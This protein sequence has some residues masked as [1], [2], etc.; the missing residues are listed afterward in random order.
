[1]EW[2]LTTLGAGRPW[3]PS[4]VVSP[5]RHNK[6]PHTESGQN[7]IEYWD[8]TMELEMLKGPEDLQLAAEL[9]K[10]LL[11][12]NRELEVSLK[13]QQT[14]ID[15]QRQEIEYLS[16]QTAALREVNDSRLRIYEQL[17][18]SIQDLE[19]N[20]QRLAAE[21]TADK[22][23]IKS[24]SS[25]V[26]SLEVRCDD[27]QRNLEEARAKV[28]HEN[29][30]Q[31]LQQQ[32]QQ[33][34]QQQRGRNKRR[35][36]LFDEQSVRRSQSCESTAQ[37]SDDYALED[38]EIR[39][40]LED[41]QEKLSTTREQLVSETLK[42]EELEIQ[43]ACLS[44]EKS[45]MLD[46]L[47]VLQEKELTVRTFDDELASLDDTS[48]G[49][50]C[51]KCLGNVD[52]LGSNPTLYD[53]NDSIEDTD[54]SIESIHG[55][56]ALIRLKN[57]GYAWGSQESL[58]S[59]GQ[60]VNHV[61]SEG[62]SP[63]TEASDAPHNSLLSEL[64]T[65]YRILIE[66]YEALLEAREQQ[67]QQ[68]QQESVVHPGLDGMSGP[69]SI[70][71]TNPTSQNTT[72][73]SKCQRC[74]T[75]TCDIEPSVINNPKGSMLDLSE[76]DTTSSGFS[77]GESHL[78]SKSTQTREELLVSQA[79]IL[80]DLTPTIHSKCLDLSSPVNPCDRRFQSTPEYKKL[81]QEI[82][83]VL[84]KTVD[85]KDTQSQP[86]KPC[87]A[88]QKTDISTEKIVSVP[89]PLRVKEHNNIK[90]DGQSVIFPVEEET[91]NRESLQSEGKND[92]N[93]DNPNV[94]SKSFEEKE[95]IILSEHN[96]T[97]SREYPN[98]K[99]R[100]EKQITST[101][102]SEQNSADIRPLRPDTLDLSSGGGSRPSSRQR[103]RR[104]QQQ[105]T[106]L[107]PC[108]Q[109]QQPQP[110]DNSQNAH[111]SYHERQQH[112]SHQRYQKRDRDG[113]HHHNYHNH[114]QQDDFPDTHSQD[115]A[116]AEVS[117]TRV[118]YNS[119][120]SGG[121]CEHHRSRKHHR[122]QQENAEQRHSGSDTELKRKPVTKINYPSVEVARLR[123][124]EMTYA[125]VLKN[126]MNRSF[127]DR[128]Y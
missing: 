92:T 109:Q 126:S 35:S 40:R 77:E 38:Y 118:V 2:R 34:Q 23:K 128:R 105:I 100:I 16:K 14:V 86:P 57:G 19:K 82:F 116:P 127:Y 52:E 12:R 42:K 81:F 63:G 17:E 79:D 41:L 7:S 24:L 50:I 9:G 15:D 71:M 72:L 58:A 123:K 36:L 88:S 97:V 25:T 39:A 4:E 114:R 13:Q 85:E 65:S 3:P 120:R 74:S 96:D 113:L 122:S 69:M 21:G 55:E 101:S 66:K 115:G 20:N 32:Q 99:E 22:K 119:S 125:E 31:Q 51:R 64:D 29:H 44:Q 56:C 11:E 98:S 33:Q 95:V 60:V 112:H 45:V 75:C 70:S 47:A 18:V 78:I 28:H 121:R 110:A 104:R 10:T 1:M 62:T 89:T 6:R 108:L 103:R 93:Q 91:E 8:Y 5:S 67:Q 124:L 53:L 102:D 106:Q 54:A 48:S 26:E 80:D 117:K 59:I 84:K 49:R 73:P 107:N 27:L 94:G 37:V 83:T 61:G 46:Q 111:H 87:K 76:V 68:Q 43:L 90:L 30:Q